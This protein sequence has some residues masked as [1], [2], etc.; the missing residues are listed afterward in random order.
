MGSS[1][2]TILPP[3]LLGWQNMHT[4]K[5]EKKNWKRFLF[6]VLSLLFL[7]YLGGG[8][9]KEEACD[10]RGVGHMLHGECKQWECVGFGV[11]S[12]ME[13]YG[14]KLGPVGMVLLLH[15]FSNFLVT[16]ITW[17]TV[18]SLLF[19]YAIFKL[20]KQKRT[21]I[22]LAKE[23]YVMLLSFTP[24]LSLSLLCG[25]IQINMHSWLWRLERRRSVKKVELCVLHDERKKKRRLKKI[26]LFSF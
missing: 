5:K 8:F 25:G 9:W 20:E 4:K 10:W 13:I 26:Y 23:A 6:E 11:S 12:A 14:G 19:I 22:N 2:H 21:N 24:P 15:R 3:S 1:H 16:Q 7:N 18:I 17:E